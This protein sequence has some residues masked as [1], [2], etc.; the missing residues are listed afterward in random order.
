MRDAY[1]DEFAD[2]GS[3]DDRV[4]WT[5]LARRTGCVSRALSYV[6]AFVGEDDAAQAETDWPSA[7][8]SSSCWRRPTS[9]GAMEPLHAFGDDALGD[10]DAVGLV[11]ALHAGRV[12]VPEVVEAAIARTEAVDPEVNAVAFRAFDRA[13]VEARE[14]RDGFFAGVPTFVKDNVDVA[15][16][17]TQQG[18]DAFV[19]RPARADGDFARMYLDTGLVPLGKTQL[20]EFGFSAAAEHVR[21]GPVRSP[22]HRDHSAGASSAGSSALV[23]A[24]AVPIAHANDGGGSIRIPASVNG[25]V[26][27]KP[28]RDRL[29][30]DK[31]LRACRSGSSPTAW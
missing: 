10:L 31:S 25:L 2:L 6:Q 24:G 26:G 29:A 7:H 12:S 27:L 11:A 19:A 17:P 9:V 22:W 4:R 3:R 30:Q 1:L 8:G 23:A 28:T 14:P 16:M 21:I 13:R 18:S 15:G 5:L 20:S